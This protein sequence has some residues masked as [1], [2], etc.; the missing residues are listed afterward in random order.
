[1]HFDCR[2]NENRRVYRKR[3]LLE[4]LYPIHIYKINRKRFCAL[5]MP[6]NLTNMTLHMSVHILNQPTYYAIMKI[7]YRHMIRN[8]RIHPHVDYNLHPTELA[9]GLGNLDIQRI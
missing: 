7:I 6:S 9:L 2:Y 3:I 4:V 1:M 5:Y 8:H